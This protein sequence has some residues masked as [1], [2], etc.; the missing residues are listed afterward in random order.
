MATSGNTL[1]DQAY[2]KCYQ[3]E[4]KN[5]TKTIGVIKSAILSS[6]YKV[7]RPQTFLRLNN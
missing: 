7:A 3:K 5:K 2:K 4:K 1:F 6:F